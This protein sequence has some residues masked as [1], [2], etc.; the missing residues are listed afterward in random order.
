MR[1]TLLFALIV[2]P[3][4]GPVMAGDLTYKEYAKAPEDWRRGYVS[5]IAEYMSVVP[6]PDEEPPYP[7]RTALKR[8]LGA[9]TDSV[10]VQRVDAYVAANRGLSDKPMNTVVLRALFD[11]CR[12]DISKVKPS[13]PSR[14]G[15]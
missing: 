5:G 14:G 12:V 10:L 11:L 4:V 6:Q 2:P 8:C 1:L 7:V 13:T 9:S 3:L 15:P